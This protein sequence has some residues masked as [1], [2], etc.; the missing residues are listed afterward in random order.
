MF[1]ILGELRTILY[2]DVVWFGYS[3]TLNKKVEQLVLSNASF[4]SIGNRIYQTKVIRTSINRPNI[5][6]CVLPLG[7]GKVDL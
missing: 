1:I 5:S 4:R 7:K 2:Q 3:T 6:I